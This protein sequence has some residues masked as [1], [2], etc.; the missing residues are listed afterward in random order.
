MISFI[1]CSKDGKK[2][3]TQETGKVTPF[4]V[5]K[6]LT[7]STIIQ[8]NEGFEMNKQG[9]KSDGFLPLGEALWLSEAGVNYEFRDEKE[10][11]KDIN[12]SVFNTTIPVTVNDD[13][14]YIVSES[15]AYNT[16]ASMVAFTGITLAENEVLVV[17]DVEIGTIE[18][19]NAN[20]T[21]TV[22]GGTAMVDPF[23]INDSD[24]WRAAYELGK[25]DGTQVGKDATWRINQILNSRQTVRY[26]TDINTELMVWN[27]QQNGYEYFW[28]GECNECL[29]PTTMQTRL[30][31]ARWVIES[32]RPDNKAV[33]LSD[34]SWEFQDNFVH[35]FDKIK[36]GVAHYDISP[37]E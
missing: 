3:K 23:L 19:G 9:F 34:F 35:C 33:V 36:Y 14:E 12:S 24:Y 13:G 10:N 29:S 25:C 27:I 8:F 6:S 2:L 15:D 11:V 5:E 18:N 26:Y 1:A 37:I 4:T 16:Y 21:M 30:D 22:A 20:L 17:S 31:D 7:K 28:N 32:L